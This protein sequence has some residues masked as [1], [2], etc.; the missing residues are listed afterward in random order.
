MA[1]RRLFTGLR[2][3][4]VIATAKLEGWSCQKRSKT[5]RGKDTDGKYSIILMQY[6]HNN[7][8]VLDNADILPT[9][10]PPPPRGI[11]RYG[12]D[13]QIQRLLPSKLVN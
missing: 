7:I 10:P 11:L 3:A 12:P 6:S 9:T 4:L 2:L 5:A 13:V 8:L 1:G